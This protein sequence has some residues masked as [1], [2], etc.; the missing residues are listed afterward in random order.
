MFVFG[1]FSGQRAQ[2]PAS[3][4]VCTVQA[5]RKYILQRCHL[6]HIR[7]GVSLPYPGFIPRCILNLGMSLV[8][9][10]VCVCCL[11]CCLCLQFLHLRLLIPFIF[12]ILISLFLCLLVSLCL[13]VMLSC[14]LSVSLSLSVCLSVCLS[15]STFLL[16]EKAK[17][18]K[19][20]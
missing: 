4:P 3:G 10:C 17:A 5:H 6:D 14:S 11:F 1:V 20:H 9:T 12:F 16:S 15:V 19:E 2:G 13:G 8:D 18:E 7:S